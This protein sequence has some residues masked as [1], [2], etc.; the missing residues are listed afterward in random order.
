MK[1]ARKQADLFDGPRDLTALFEAIETLKRV[2]IAALP[3][4]ELDA[5]TRLVL[6]MNKEAL[7]LALSADGLNP[8]ARAKIRGAYRFTLALLSEDE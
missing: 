6:Q 1:A 2:A 3:N 8:G 4:A 7:R 5:N